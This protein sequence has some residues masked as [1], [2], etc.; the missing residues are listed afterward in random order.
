MCCV[1]VFQTT[2]FTSSV[3]DPRCFKL[4]DDDAMT[5]FQN[6]T[7]SC[8][9]IYLSAGNQNTTNEFGK[10]ERNDKVAFKTINLH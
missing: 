5:S 6:I 9:I 8:F 1:Y 2:K 3:F 10:V 4:D 7:D